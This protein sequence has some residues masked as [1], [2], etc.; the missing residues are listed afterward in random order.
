MKLWNIGP[1]AK[2][3]KCQRYKVEEQESLCHLM[4]Q[5]EDTR[6]KFEGKKNSKHANN[7]IKQYGRYIIKAFLG[8]SASDRIE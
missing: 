2:I 4:W 3:Y 7:I 5:L 1:R 8:K 6:I